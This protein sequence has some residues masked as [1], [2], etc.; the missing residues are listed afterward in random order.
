MGGLLDS[1]DNFFEA[2]KG[3]SHEAHE[4]VFIARAMGFFRL[5]IPIDDFYTKLT[6]SSDMF[7][8][9][10]ME[11]ASKFWQIV[12]VRILIPKLMQLAGYATELGNGS[13]E[14]LPAFAF[15]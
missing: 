9:I 10:S 15:K 7:N 3:A 13:S 5:S 12:G 4:A 2:K 6:N 8:H 11:V 14:D 1:M